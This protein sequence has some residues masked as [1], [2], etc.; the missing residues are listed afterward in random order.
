[1]SSATRAVFAG[2]W[3]GSANNIMDYVTIA[4]TGDAVDFGDS[5][6]TIY[7]SDGCSDVHGGLG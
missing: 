3:K 1:M 6:T 5:T 2:L 7:Y 4:T